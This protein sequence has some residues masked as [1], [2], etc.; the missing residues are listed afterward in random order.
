MGQGGLPMGEGRECI[1]WGGEWK[2]GEGPREML[3]QGWREEGELGNRPPKLSLCIL[4]TPKSTRPHS[5]HKI[6]LH[7]MLSVRTQKPS[8]LTCPEGV[9]GRR[10]GLTPTQPVHATGMGKPVAAEAACFLRSAMRR[11]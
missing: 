11:L 1:E 6:T 8:E 7:L 10:H 2:V 4:E 3:G 5:R 9:A